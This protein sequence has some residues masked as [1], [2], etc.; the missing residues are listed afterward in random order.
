MGIVRDVRVL[1]D[2]IHLTVKGDRIERGP[3]GLNGGEP[4]ARLDFL[5]DPGTSRER[6]LRRADNGTVLPAGSIVRVLSA[7]GGG[8]GAP[9]K[10][11]PGARRNDHLDGLEPAANADSQGTRQ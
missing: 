1:V 4:G 11:D 10:R 5:L 6:H 9:D 2:G 7:G 8:Y 3:W